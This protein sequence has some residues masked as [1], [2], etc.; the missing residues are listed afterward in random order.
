[1]TLARLLRGDAHKAFVKSCRQLKGFIESQQAK[2]SFACGGNIPIA[3]PRTS[4]TETPTSVLVNI[5]WS[6]GNDSTASKLV[7]P[8]NG[9]AP[10]PVQMSYND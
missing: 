5:F 4:D 8:V 6:A 7:L 1:M 3:A 2:V 9:A 10:G